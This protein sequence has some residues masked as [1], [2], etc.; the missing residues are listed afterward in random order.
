MNQ[1]ILEAFASSNRVHVIDFSLRQGMLWPALMQVRALRPRGP[2]TIRLTGIWPPQPDNIYAL[3]QVGWKLAQ[4]AETI[5]MEFEFR[6][7]VTNSL[8]DLDV[9]MLEIM[10]GD[11]EL[12]ENFDGFLKCFS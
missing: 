11:D 4:L 5:G 6:G 7:F 1:A 2:P 10:A 8:A 12:L 3:Q 9:E